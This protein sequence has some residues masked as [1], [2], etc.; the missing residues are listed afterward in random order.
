MYDSSSDDDENLNI[1]VHKLEGED[2]F[3]IWEFT[4]IGALRQQGL[5]G[6]IRGTETRPIGNTPED[7]KKLEEFNNGKFRAWYILH[8]SVEPLA[9]RKHIRG[10]GPLDD[11]DNCD[12]K[13]LWDELQR[14]YTDIGPI[15]KLDLL[16]ELTSIDYRQFDDIEAFLNRAQ[17]LE[18]RLGR[19]GM[20][21]SDEMMKTCLYGGV[22][23]HPSKRL[24]SL[25]MVKYDEWDSKTMI[26]QMRGHSFT[27]QSEANKHQREQQEA[28]RRRNANRQSSGHRRGSRRRGRR[29]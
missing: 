29:R 16:K 26:S 20:P 15:R 21:I 6:F 27:I 23:H 28:N 1:E 3:G 19:L 22:L 9:A 4:T 13:L 5:E 25:L 10:W 18:R 24:E 12:P 17:K 8:Q 14:W 11:L 2:N 7:M